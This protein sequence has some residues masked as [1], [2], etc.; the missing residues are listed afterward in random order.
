MFPT[1]A[2]FVEALE[3]GGRASGPAKERS[4]GAFKPPPFLPPAEVTSCALASIS[5]ARRD[6][7]YVPSREEVVPGSKGGSPPRHA[8]DGNGKPLYSSPFT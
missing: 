4:R 8:R 7:K 5:L 1:A 3:G 6:K 2:L